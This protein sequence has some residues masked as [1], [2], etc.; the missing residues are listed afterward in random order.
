MCSLVNFPDRLCKLLCA[1]VDRIL[2]LKVRGKD[3]PGLGV[4]NASQVTVYKICKVIFVETG[5][6][7]DRTVLYNSRILDKNCHAGCLCD[8]ASCTLLERPLYIF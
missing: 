7:S 6:A 1:S 3:P 2:L 8:G 5:S 4:V